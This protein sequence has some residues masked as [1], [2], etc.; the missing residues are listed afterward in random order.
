MIFDTYIN[1]GREM[2]S[3][4]LRSLVLIFA[5]YFAI[6]EGRQVIISGIRRYIANGWNYMDISIISLIYVAE[7]MQGNTIDNNVTLDEIE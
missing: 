3:K 2:A 4:A 5:S 1:N 7:I 6:L